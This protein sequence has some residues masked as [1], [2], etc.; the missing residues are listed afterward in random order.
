MG[1]RQPRRGRNCCQGRLRRRQGLQTR[2]PAGRPQSPRLHEG[3][4]LP[5]HRACRTPLPHRPGNQPRHPRN[6][7]RARHG[8]PLRG[9][10]LRTAAGGEARP[11]RLPVRR[12]RGPAQEERERI[13]PRRRP[14]GHRQPHAVARHQPVGLPFAPLRGR[15]LR[16]LLSGPRTR[17]AQLVRL[18]PRRHHHRPGGRDPRRQGRRVHAAQDRRGLQPRRGEDPP[19]LAQGRRRGTRSQQGPRSRRGQG[20]AR[21]QVHRIPQDRLHRANPRPPDSA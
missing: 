7:L 10:D 16:R 8:R 5:R 21:P 19:A 13:P 15:A 18:R 3:A 9:F 4:R 6:H 1:E 14:Q 12:R 20:R 2:R 17:A 11:D